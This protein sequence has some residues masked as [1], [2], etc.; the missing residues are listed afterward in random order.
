MK[1]LFAINGDFGLKS[2]HLQVIPFKLRN[3]RFILH[4]QN[5][6]LHCRPSPFWAGRMMRMAVPSPSVL[7]AQMIPPCPAIICLAI[8]RP[9]PLPPVFVFL[10]S[11]AR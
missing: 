8:A 10:D 9:S 7:S 4:N 1:S 11:S 3:G 5:R 6:S 2:V